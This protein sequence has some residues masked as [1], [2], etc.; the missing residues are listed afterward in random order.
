MRNVVVAGGSLAAVSAANAL[1]AAGFDGRITMVSAESRAPYS[2]PPLSKDI[3]SG[4]HGPG[5]ADLP[6]ADGI[7]LRLGVRAAGLDTAARRVRLSDGDELPY[8]GLVVATGARAHRLGGGFTLR[9]MDDALALRDALDAA[10]D[11]LIVGAGPLGMEIA[12]VCLARR[13]PTTVVDHMPPLRRHLGRHLSDLAVRAAREAGV[14]F[15]RPRAPATF[16]ADG[17]TVYAD[18]RALTADVIVTAAGD[19]P[20]VE[21]LAGS[22]LEITADGLVVDARLRAAPEIVGAGDAVVRRGAAR[23]PLW[24]AALEQGRAA[25]LT[26]LSPD[27]PAHVPR[28][29]FWTEQFG[30]SIK[31]CGPVPDDAEPLTVSGAPAERSLVLRWPPG[32]AP[33]CAASVNHPMPIAKLRRLAA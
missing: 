10:G 25:A 6:L 22:G 13:L 4:T 17:R 11:V 20:N 29:Y 31:V 19:R 1:R 9:T 30:L 33:G 15:V 26:L 3:L 23:T 28:P 27:V 14:R 5:S 32:D 12:S 18:G 7:E 24:T 21:W 16:A 8:D 2:R